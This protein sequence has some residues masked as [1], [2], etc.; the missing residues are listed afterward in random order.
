MA[1]KS[2]MAPPSPVCKMNQP[3]SIQP[4]KM[5]RPRKVGDIPPP[6]PSQWEQPPPHLLRRAQNQQPYASPP[7]GAQSKWTCPPPPPKNL[8]LPDGGQENQSPYALRLPM[9]GDFKPSTPWKTCVWNPGAPSA[10]V[11][12]EAKGAEAQRESVSIR[13]NSP[14]AWTTLADAKKCSNVDDAIVEAVRSK[15][16]AQSDPQQTP[17][18]EQSKKNKNSEKTNAQKRKRLSYFHTNIPAKVFHLLF[19]LTGLCV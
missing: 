2:K 17:S 10:G 15:R 9:R 5:P 4:P 19:A 16:Q 14:C 8:R 7:F 1:L 11:A 6:F 12:G 13:T 18:D 3:R